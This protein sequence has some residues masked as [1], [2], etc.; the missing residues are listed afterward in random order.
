MALPDSSW[1][2]HHRSGGERR[3]QRALPSASVTLNRAWLLAHPPNL[4][5]RRAGRAASGSEGRM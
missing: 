5:P 3:P 1:R 2:V 4:P